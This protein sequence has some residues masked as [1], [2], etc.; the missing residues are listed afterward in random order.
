M[1]GTVLKISLLRLLNSK[2]D[3]LLIFVV[4][5]LFFSIF[6]MIFSRGVGSR[7]KTVSVSI[8]NDDPS[9][10]TATV[11]QRL[12]QADELKRATGIG[13]TTDQWPIEKL[14][15]AIMSSRNV[16]VVVY[17]PP[18]FA[19]VQQTDQPKTVQI[20]NEGTNPVS[21]RIVEAALSKALLQDIPQFQLPA[22]TVQLASG[23]STG[24]G[25]VHLASHA[26]PSLPV[27]HRSVFA[28]NKHEPKIAMYAAGIAV[29]FLLF[30]SIG[31]GASLLEEKEAGT[32]E[33]LLGS[34]LS[35]GQLLL[36]KW[37][38]I[39]GLGC[40]QLTVMFVWGWLV[41]DVDLAGHWLGFAVISTATSAACASFALFLAVLCKSRTQLNGVALV[42]V[43]SMSA[44]GG[45]MIPRY[46]M[47]ESMQQLGRLT[48][49]GWALDAYKK[50]FWY[51]LTVAAIKTEILV[52]LGIA[53]VLGLAAR[54]FANQW[55]LR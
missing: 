45:S 13:S 6:A 17:F 5:I 18:D 42:V 3:L 4:P 29:M 38:Y 35:I 1:I 43:L 24:S 21:S 44:L 14:A 11:I 28:S 51:D 34:R 47:S 27:E 12:L 48:F 7:V 33:R 15:R 40:L 22:S 10:Q 50:I 37:L 26:P 39:A 41:F 20:L 23:V 46:L 31:A 52:L 2:Q 53:T 8:V 49:N 54:A 55:S 30:S 9:P 16:E 32:L 25:A 19:K 36:G